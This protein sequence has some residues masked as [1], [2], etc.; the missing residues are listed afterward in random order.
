[1]LRSAAPKYGG[2]L[3]GD[4]GKWVSPLFGWKVGV[5]FVVLF[6]RTLAQFAAE[7]WPTVANQVTPVVYREKNVRRPPT[8]FRIMRLSGYPALPRKP[9]ETRCLRSLSRSI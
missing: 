7:I 3:A 2:L 1:M 9:Y 4:H 5:P 6:V 8:G